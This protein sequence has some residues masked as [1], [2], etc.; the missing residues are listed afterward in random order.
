ML[1]VSAGTL[2]HML[3][4]S[5]IRNKPFWSSVLA[6]YEHLYVYVYGFTQEN[7]SR[8]LASLA[9]VLCSRLS[10][11]RLNRLRCQTLRFTVSASHPA[12]TEELTGTQ[13]D[14]DNRFGDSGF[15]GLSEIPGVETIVTINQLASFIK[16]ERESYTFFVHATEQVLDLDEATQETELRHRFSHFV[17]QLMFLRHAFG[18]R[19]WRSPRTYANFIIDDPYLRPRYGFVNMAQLAK[20]AV[21]NDFAA[22]IALIPWNYKKTSR[23]T[24]TLFR[25][26]DS[27]LSICM[28][29]CDHTEG[30]FGT[31]DVDKLHSLVALASK[32]MDQHEQ[33]TGI[34]CEKV[35]VFPQGVFSAAAMHALK[36]GRF[37][38]A[39][40]SHLDCEESDRPQLTFRDILDV[41]VMSY[42]SLPLFSRRYPSEDGVEFCL[43]AFLNKPVLSVEHHG[44]FKPGYKPIEAFVQRLQEMNTDLTWTGLSSALMHSTIEKRLNDGTQMCRL[45]CRKAIIVNRLSRAQSYRIVRR[46]EDPC[47]IVEVRADGVRVTHRTDSEGLAFDLEIEAHGRRSVEIV[48]KPAEWTATGTRASMSYTLQ[49]WWRRTLSELRDNYLCKNDTV[50]SLAKSL[51][52]RMMN[53]RVAT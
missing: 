41:A 30:E 22:T 29:G 33:R 49:V 35:M 17:P 2:D 34:P 20:N 15:S 8:V 5:P 10:H 4:G 51:K 50:L 12:L 11:L 42:S 38:A 27:R 1:A 7:C 19:C 46:E 52:H 43:D 45:Y 25:G 32:R 24:G 53:G 6:S 47:A 16:V 44:F 23:A 31:R 40:N 13:F 14:S 39:A 36:V 18:D 21:K 9:D 37:I 26:P 3:N 28:H 48:Y